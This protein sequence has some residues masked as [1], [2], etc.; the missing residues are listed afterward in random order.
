MLLMFFVGIVLSQQDICWQYG[1]CDPGPDCNDKS[2]DLTISNDK[3]FSCCDDGYITRDRV[4]D[5]NPDC[6]NGIDEDPSYCS[7][8]NLR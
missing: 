4:C 7:G 3:C 2:N 5:G 6:D 1:N 8:K